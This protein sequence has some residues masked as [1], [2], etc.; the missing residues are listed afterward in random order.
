MVMLLLQYKEIHF[1]IFNVSSFS[2]L[3]ISNGKAFQAQITSGKEECLSYW[4]VKYLNFST[5]KSNGKDNLV[6][7]SDTGKCIVVVRRMK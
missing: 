4:D 6:S 7:L 3:H 5:N 1:S 2:S